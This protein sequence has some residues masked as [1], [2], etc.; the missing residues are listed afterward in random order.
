[1]SELALKSILLVAI[2]ST[3]VGALA[4]LLVIAVRLANTRLGEHLLT[5]RAGRALLR[6]YPVR[7][8]AH[9]LD[10]NLLH[11]VAFAEMAQD[12]SYQEEVRKIESEFAIADWQAFQIAEQS[13]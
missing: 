13:R 11:S 1:M 8:L 7:Q 4:S 3:V 10:Y 2:V 6:L 9:W 12:Q 5:R